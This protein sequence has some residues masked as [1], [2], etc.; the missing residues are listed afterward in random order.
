VQQNA[1]DLAASSATIGMNY[2]SRHK[3]SG[4]CI[5][6]HWRAIQN[7]SATLMDLPDTTNWAVI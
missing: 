3:S 2:S 7:K 6:K 5:N 1:P 4:M